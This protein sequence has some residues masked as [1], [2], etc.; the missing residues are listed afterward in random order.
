MRGVALGLVAAVGMAGCSKP[1]VMWYLHATATQ[2]VYRQ[3]WF[4]HHAIDA[5]MAQVAAEPLILLEE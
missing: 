2:H 1:Q 5:L 4:Y 3:D